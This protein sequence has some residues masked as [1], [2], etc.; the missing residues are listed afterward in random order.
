MDLDDGYFASTEAGIEAAEES[1]AQMLPAAALRGSWRVRF[2][3]YAA[4][5]CFGWLR[6]QTVVPDL[7]TWA[8]IYA[9]G[10]RMLGRAAQ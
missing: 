3:L 8:S 1:V 5:S 10:I 9:T 6:S 7:P 2:Y 4:N